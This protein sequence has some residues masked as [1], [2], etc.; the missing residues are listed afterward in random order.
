MK[1]KIKWMILFCLVEV[2]LFGGLNSFGQTEEEA[3]ES[4]FILN[5]EIKLHEDVMQ[6]LDKDIDVFMQKIQYQSKLIHRKQVAKES[7]LETYASLLRVQ[8]S[9]GKY[10]YL[11]HILHASNIKGVIKSIHEER[12]LSSMVTEMVLAIENE[13][14]SIERLTDSIA[15]EKKQLENKVNRLELEKISYKNKLEEQSRFLNQYVDTTYFLVKV[16]VLTKMWEDIQ[17]TFKRKIESFNLLIQNQILPEDIFNLRRTGLKLEASLIEE[18]FNEALKNQTIVKDMSF[19][20]STKGVGISFQNIDVKLNGQFEISNPQT[21]RFDI[22]E[23][24]FKDHLLSI[25]ALEHFLEGVQLQFD[26]SEMLGKSTIE[27]VDVKHGEI[28]LEIQ[29]KLF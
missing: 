23:A 24:Y 12:M 15:S 19:D 18:R 4:Y 14:L 21:I 22:K 13:M 25:I 11:N 5:Q 2:Y 28:Q 27:K 29:L 8:Q 1:N 9:R 6:S 7:L 3:V 17:P 20:F 10:F 16:D 26:L